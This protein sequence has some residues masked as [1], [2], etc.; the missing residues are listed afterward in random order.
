M[1]GGQ[2]RDPSFDLTPMCYASG[3][4]MENVHHVVA[5]HGPW[6]SKLMPLSFSEAATRSNRPSRLTRS[7]P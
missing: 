4:K 5:G 7:D 6:S 3:G 1:E 2:V